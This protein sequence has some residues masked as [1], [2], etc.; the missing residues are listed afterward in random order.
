MLRLKG[1]TKTLQL[2]GSG[3][4]MPIIATTGVSKLKPGRWIQR[5]IQE[6]HREDRRS[7]RLFQRRMRV[8][9]LIE[10][11]E[12]FMDVLVSVQ[13]NSDLID[14][15]LDLRK[16]AGILRTLR[17]GPTSHATNLQI[18]PTL[19]NSINRWREIGKNPTNEQMI[20]HYAEV[21]TLKP[22]F[23]RFSKSL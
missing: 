9:K 14:Q 11:E 6:I 15:D 19:T 22:T 17:R 4:E 12:D 2:A 10:F 18:S 8:P 7:G 3:F 5:L 23:L 1:R 13:L 21:T 16:E 20:D